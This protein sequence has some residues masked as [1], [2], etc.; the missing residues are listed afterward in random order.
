MAF[1]MKLTGLDQLQ[2]S[3]KAMPVVMQ[4]RIV[5]PAIT[6]AAKI[7]E[8]AIAGLIPYNTRRRGRKGRHAHYKTS[9]TSVVRQLASGTVVGVIG[10]ESGMAPHAAI[11]EEGTRQRFTNSKPVYRR[12]ATGVKTV[13]KRGKA[14]TRVVRQKKSIGSKAKDKKPQLNRGR[15]PAFRPVQRGVEQSQSAVTATLT[16]SIQSGITREF[17]AAKLS[18]G[19]T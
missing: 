8:R 16:Q 13:I 9:M 4:S 7:V 18:R 6:D 19:V 11:V 5:M 3:L 14:V 12:M 1:Q 2:R 10:A 15:M 17:T